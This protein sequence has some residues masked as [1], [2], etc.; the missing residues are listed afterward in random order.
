M[1]ILIIINIYLVVYFVILNEQYYNIMTK[2]LPGIIIM[3]INILSHIGI[4][5]FIFKLN[6]MEE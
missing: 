1:I 2:T 3:N 6:K 5:G 4:L